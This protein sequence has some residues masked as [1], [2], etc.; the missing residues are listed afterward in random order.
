METLSLDSLNGIRVESETS[1]EK[2]PLH[3]SPVKTYLLDKDYILA[4][5][6]RYAQ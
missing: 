4:Q 3:D 1:P 2:I 6:S 5:A